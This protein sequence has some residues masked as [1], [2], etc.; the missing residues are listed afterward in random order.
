M[1]YSDGELGDE[2]PPAEDEGG[3]GRGAGG[4]ADGAVGG[5][6]V[7]SEEEGPPDGA[8]HRLQEPLIGLRSLREVGVLEEEPHRVLPHVLRR[9]CAA[10]AVEHLREGGSFQAMEVAGGGRRGPQQSSYSPRRRR[11]EWG[12]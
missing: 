7:V 9:V 11:W 5:E 4:A 1:E 10:V 2:D 8:R 12:I 3:E 6:G